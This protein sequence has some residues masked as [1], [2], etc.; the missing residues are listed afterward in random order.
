[1][2]L[3][4]LMLGILFSVSA[5]A[6]GAMADDFAAIEKA[7]KK[8]GVVTWYTQPGYPVVLKE[9]MDEFT[10]KYGIR[11]ETIE[12]NG[13]ANVERIRAELR[14]GRVAADIVSLGNTAAW[15]LQD[16]EKGLAPFKDEEIPN[17]ANLTELGKKFM[18]PNNEYL[19]IAVGVYGIGVNTSLVKEAD[20]PKGWADILNP[21]FKDKIGL[22]DF[23]KTGGGLVWLTVGREPLGMEFF[24]KF[25][26]QNPR[27][28]P[29]AQQNDAALAR[30]ERAIA[31]AP[32]SRIVKDHPGAPLKWVRPEEGVY[33]LDVTTGLVRGGPHPNAAKLLLNQMLSVAAQKAHAEQ[34]DLPVIKGVKASFDTEGLKFLGKGGLTREDVPKLGDVIK[35]GKSL[36]GER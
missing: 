13:S 21:K 34:G 25:A 2:K 16:Q 1:M 18:D 12:G 23:R 17:L 24:E 20:Y 6:S 19:P 11:I 15:R 7:G 33:T 27:V 3:K 22:H 30:G 9:A 32:R 5:S 28:Y 36:I 10:N 29:S 35:I 4:S 8:E 31:I 26:A 14:S